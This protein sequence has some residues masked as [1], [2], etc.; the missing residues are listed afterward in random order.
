MNA[1]VFSIFVSCTYKCPAH[2]DTKYTTIRWCDEYL[3]HYVNDTKTVEEQRCH[4]HASSF[5]STL[6]FW[7][8]GETMFAVSAGT[9]V[10]QKVLKEEEWEKKAIWNCWLVYLIGCRLVVSLAVQSKSKIS[11]QLSTFVWDNPKSHSAKGLSLK[12]IC[13]KPR[14]SWRHLSLYNCTMSNHIMCNKTWNGI[15]LNYTKT[16]FWGCH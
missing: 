4:P 3:L 2:V 5:C 6:I 16:P 1:V 9:P 11:L 13:W 10:H 12:A 8:H 15:Y 7:K 14:A